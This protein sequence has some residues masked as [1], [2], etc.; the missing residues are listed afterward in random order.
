MPSTIPSHASPV[1]APESAGHDPTPIE[2]DILNYIIGYLRANTYQPSVREIGEHFDIGSTRTVSSHLRALELK[3]LIERSQPRSRGV[4]LKGVDLG[5][6]S[7][8]VPYLSTLPPSFDPGQGIKTKERMSLD[9]RM[10]G[11]DG[12]FVVA[13]DGASLVTLGVGRDDLLVLVP[14][15]ASE[16]VAGMTVAA[17]VNGTSGYFTVGTHGERTLL[18]PLTADGPAVEPTEVQVIGR[19][20]SVWHRLD[21][22][23]PLGLTTH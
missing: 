23:P 14:A 15:H 12:A 19:I 3:G 6:E 17:T 5:G 8:T 1:P 18:E 11:H 22:S 4:R 7:V 13:A 9:R 10:G 2:R 16:L 21:H 20:I